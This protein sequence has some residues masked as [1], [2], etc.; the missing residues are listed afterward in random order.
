MITDL[1]KTENKDLLTDDMVHELLAYFADP[2]LEKPS[3]DAKEEVREG[4][5]R[6]LKYKNGL[7]KFLETPIE[8]L[9]PEMKDIKFEEVGDVT[10]RS[11]ME[12][13]E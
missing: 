9:I 6:L 10:A 4:R 12:N 1:V 5:K 11:Q 2:D 13:N 3:D 7:I 8:E